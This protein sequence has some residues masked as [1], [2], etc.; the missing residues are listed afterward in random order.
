MKTVADL[1]RYLVKGAK[2]T[3]IWAKD[4]KHKNLNIERYVVKVQG[5]GVE[6]S[7]NPEDKRGSFLDFPP[8]TLCDVSENG[9]AI[10][11]V[12]YRELTEQE[13][14]ILE[15]EKGLCTEEE[16]HND[17]ISDGSTCYWRKVR[18]YDTKY[19]E[20]KYLFQGE[21]KGMRLSRGL[22]MDNKVK[23]EKFLEYSIN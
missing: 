5:N 12:G 21:Q 8:A 1:K 16:F 3:L 2:V 10:Y 23:G 6:L 22:V 4:S 20:F 17:M 19:P 11:L 15:E 14:A 18:F 13:R 7:V 9:F